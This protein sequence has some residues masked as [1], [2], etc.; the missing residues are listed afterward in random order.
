MAGRDVLDDI[1]AKR[2][3]MD[4]MARRVPSVVDRYKA[5]L[6]AQAVAGPGTVADLQGNTEVPEAAQ[7]TAV[8]YR[9][10]CHR[11]ED[12]SDDLWEELRGLYAGGPKLLRDEALMRRI[13][14]S[15]RNEDPD[16]YKERVA[17]AFYFPYAGSIIDQLLAGLS[18]DPVRVAHPCVEGK[19]VDLDPWWADW[20]ADVSPLGGERQALRQL[21]IEVMRECLVTKWTW[22]LV[23]RPPRPGELR[24]CSRLEEERSPL[25]RPYAV[26][27]RAEHVIDWEVDDAGE[28]EWVMICDRARRRSASLTDTR[29]LITETYTQ[30]TRDAWRRWRVTYH[31]ERPPKPSELIAELDGGANRLGKVPVERVELPD[32]LWAMGKLESLAREHLNKRNAV[33]WAEYKSLFAV[34]YEFLAPEEPLM[35]EVS[36]AGADPTRAMSQVFS[37]GHSQLRGHQDKAQYIGPDVAPFSEGRQSCQEIMREMHRVTSVM[38]QSVEMDSSALRRSGESK[39]QDHAATNVVLRALGQ[40]LR[41]A[42]D[43]VVRLVRAT[44]R[45]T[46]PEL[47]VSGAERFDEESVSSSIADAVELLNGVPQRSPTF[48]QEFLF[49]VYKLALGT[50][51]A[52]DDV[53]AQV[54]E[55]VRR[56][57]TAESLALG[58]SMPLP[59]ASGAPSP[60]DPEQDDDWDDDD[61]P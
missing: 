22:V 36:A 13:F 29:D 60:E 24:F 37:P 18:A 21:A 49:R 41:D 38:A 35:G 52:T 44:R 9:F 31:P 58:D 61:D 25:N 48:V 4:P 3:A 2:D 23:D 56:F 32:G 5:H 40:I 55:E 50:A 33:S 39:A 1:Q 11:N 53:L 47:V 27:L 46:G 30:I 51:H 59:S 6:A 16:I 42:I 15:H 12:Y 57:V 14:P 34:L 20:L 10:L 28:L 26:I 54:R 43:R 7:A 17:R 8:E 45:D 19:E